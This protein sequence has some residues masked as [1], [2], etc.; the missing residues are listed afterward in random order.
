MAKEEVFSCICENVKNRNNFME[1]V[2]KDRTALYHKNCPT[3]GIRIVEELPLV[4]FR[5]QA[6]FTKRQ[7]AII[8][9]RWIEPKLIKTS[10]DGNLGLVEFTE[11]RHM[12]TEERASFYRDE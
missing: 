1:V 8:G 11:F 7:L 6:W 5:A 4:A 9:H 3:H 12:T 2:S 10:E